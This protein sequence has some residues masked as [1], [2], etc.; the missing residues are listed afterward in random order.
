MID[1]TF[2]ISKESE[3]DVG[4]VKAV[5]ERRMKD[6]PAFGEFGQIALPRRPCLLYGNEYFRLADIDIVHWHRRLTGR[7]RKL[8]LLHRAEPYT[9]V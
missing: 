1:V 5:G 3:S 8:Q 6:R 9:L 2:A 7:E 4:N